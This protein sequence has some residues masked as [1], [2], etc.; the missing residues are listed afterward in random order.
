MTTDTPPGGAVRPEILIADLGRLAAIAC[1]QCAAR[2]C[3]HDSLFS[4]IL[5]FKN[6]P[7]CLACLSTGLDREA[8]ELRDQLWTH[9]QKREC[10]RAGWEWA[11]RREGY[12]AAAL[13]GCRGSGFGDADDGERLETETMIQFDKEW[14]AGDMGC[15]DLVLELRLTLKAMQGGQVL[16]LRATDAGAP[17]DIPAWCGLTGHTLLETDP[18]FY[19]IKRKD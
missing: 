14:D 12:P 10:W 13:P 11:N 8:A 16:K 18:P 5:G 1:S 15:G 9:I 17:Q 19:I 6:A 2:L 7:Q 4:V 3:G